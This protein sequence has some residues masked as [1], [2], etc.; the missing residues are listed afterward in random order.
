MADPAPPRKR[1]KLALQG[2]GS[3][4]AFTWGVLDRL[5][6]ESWLTFDGISGTSA[7]AMNAAV[8]AS[9]YAH[10]GADGAKAAL[11]FEV[12]KG[13]PPRAAEGLARLIKALPLTLTGTAPMDTAISTAGGVAWSALDERLMLKAVPDT[14]CVGEMIAWDAPTGGY[15]LTACLAMGRVTGKA[16]AT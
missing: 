2:G 16:A 10:G 3:H 4:G 14:Y 6:E 15:L 11:L 1:I 7:G 5:L 13:A 8:M 12:T 9:G